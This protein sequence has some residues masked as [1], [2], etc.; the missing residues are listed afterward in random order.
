MY[1]YLISI[2]LINIAC[3]CVHFHVMAL[4]TWRNCF[5]TLDHNLRRARVSSLNRWWWW[6]LLDWSHCHG[7]LSFL[8]ST[9]ALSGRFFIGSIAGSDQY[10]MTRLLIDSSLLRNKDKSPF[11]ARW[12]DFFGGGIARFLVSFLSNLVS[13]SRSIQ[14]FFLNWKQLYRVCV[15]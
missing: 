6:F 11:V 7:P 3:L 5:F 15:D 12:Q 14:I 1:I 2:T 4:P 10:R 9:Q 13:E 8:L